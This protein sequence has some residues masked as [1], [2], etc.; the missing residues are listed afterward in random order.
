MKK[1]RFL[2]SAILLSIFLILISTPA[3]ASPATIVLNNP[4]PNDI[5][6]LGIGESYTFEVEVTSDEAFTWAMALSDVYF[7]GRGIFFSGHDIVNHDTTATLHLTVT[8]KNSTV[9][10]PNGMN[11]AAVVAGVRYQGGVI[12]YER[13]DFGVVVTP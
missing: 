13:F 4:P 2:I 9:N 10:L 3:Q 6:E 8:G 7:P 12:V 5:L 1:S 11:P